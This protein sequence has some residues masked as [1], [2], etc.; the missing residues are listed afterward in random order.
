MRWLTTL[1]LEAYDIVEEKTTSLNL[2][3]LEDLAA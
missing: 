1:A 2:E 3:A